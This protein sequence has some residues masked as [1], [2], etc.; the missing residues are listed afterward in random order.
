MRDLRLQRGEHLL[1]LR[2]RRVED[3]VKMHLVVTVARGEHTGRRQPRS[4]LGIVLDR[5]ANQADIQVE[6]RVK[7]GHG[8]L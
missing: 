7:S 2:S 3:F 8:Q 5:Y 1:F 6:L 4:L